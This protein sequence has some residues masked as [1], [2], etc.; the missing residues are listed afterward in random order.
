MVNSKN[1]KLRLNFIKPQHTHTS[2]YQGKLGDYYYEETPAAIPAIILELQSQV[3]F[4]TQ[5][6]AI[7]FK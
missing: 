5:V 1:R 4:E 6:M 2:Q 7:H 3:D